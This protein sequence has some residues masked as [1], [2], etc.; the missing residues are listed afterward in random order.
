MKK[1][2]VPCRQKILPAISALLLL[3]MFSSSSM[4]SALKEGKTVWETY[5]Q[6][7]LQ[8]DGRIIDTFQKDFSHSEAQA[9]GLLL[10]LKFGE[11]E[12]FHRIAKW[13]R[14]NL[15]QRRSD[16]LFCWA[17]GKRPGGIWQVTDYNN[18]SD[19]DILIAWAMLRAG[20]AWDDKKL[21]QDALKI[22]K[23][24]R[25][26]LF[27][28]SGGKKVLLPGYSGFLHA[29]DGEDSIEY[30]P[31]YFI[32]AAFR[33]FA[34]TDDDPAFWKQALTDGFALNDSCRFGK[35]R[36]TPDWVMIRD[37]KPA[38]SP[39][40]PGKYGYDAVRLWLYLAL[41][42][43]DTKSGSAAYH[44]TASLDDLEKLILFSR[45]ERWIPAEVMLK[46][47]FTSSHD[48]PAG[49]YMIYS[50]AMAL[51]GNT[52]LARQLKQRAFEKIHEEKADYYSCN[53]FLLALY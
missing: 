40:R 7:F 17:W 23:D 22:I 21:E 1:S 18:A 42:L 26:L 20:H 8:Q 14:D 36:L 15:Q 29:Q 34:G 25:T 41:Y 45:P 4:A 9:Y 43:D 35:F 30:N 38:L 2:R 52:E 37:G 50:R 39:K 3:M 13:T 53:I 48:A 16:H 46:D 44:K 33:D 11:R 31:S 6:N 51:Q 49:F 10:A 28:S 47:D 27:A 12:V 24:I 32:P 5:K 19:A